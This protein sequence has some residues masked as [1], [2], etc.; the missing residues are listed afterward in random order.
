MHLKRKAL[1]EFHQLPEQQRMPWV[2]TNPHIKGFHQ[3]IFHDRRL[4]ARSMH[5]TTPLRTMQ[6]EVEQF[7]KK[8]REKLQDVFG[9]DGKAPKY[10]KLTPFAIAVLNVGH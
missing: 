2:S 3:D 10:L 4:F 7:D 1:R 5:T 6:F 8:F 9:A